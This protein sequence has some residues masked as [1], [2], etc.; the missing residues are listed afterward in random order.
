MCAQAPQ[1]DGTVTAFKRSGPKVAEDTH[2]MHTGHGDWLLGAMR[3][4][5]DAIEVSLSWKQRLLWQERREANQERA[6]E[7]PLKC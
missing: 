5:L 1:A 6:T 4:T 2:L 7:E 3:T